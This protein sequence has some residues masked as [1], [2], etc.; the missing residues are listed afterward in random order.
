ME[1]ITQRT[2]KTV[3]LFLLLAFHV[4]VMS[5]VANAKVIER[6][7]DGKPKIVETVTAGGQY[8]YENHTQYM[9]KTGQP[10]HIVK[11][12]YKTDRLFSFF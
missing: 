1:Q 6:F 11:K 5:V 2:I 4:L 9:E 8:R 12:T 10:C 3:H 7:P